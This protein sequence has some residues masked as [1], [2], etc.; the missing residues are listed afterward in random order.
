MTHEK[1]DIRSADEEVGSTSLPSTENHPV[2]WYRSTFY[3]ALILGLCNFLAPGIW[4]AMNSVG[5]GG[6]EKPYL[7]NA[8]NALTFCLMV[9]S[10]F[11]GSVVVRY[12]GIKWT[13][14]VGTMGYA[15]YAAGLYTNNRFG[16]EWFVLFGA[17]LCGLS[18]GIFWMAE[19]A[20]AISYPEPHN[21][22]RFLGFWLS[23]RVGGQILGGAINLGINSNRN[24]AG[25]VSYAVL[26]VF[27]VLQA[28]GP[29]AGLLLN[30]PSQVQRTDG[31]PVKL[32]IAHS[33]LHEI[34]ETAK[35][36]FTRNFLLIV[37]LISQAVFTEAVMFT[38]LSLWFSVRARALGSF[39][40]GIIALILGNLLG[41]FLDTKRISLKTRTRSAFATILTLQ[42][43]WWV[44]GTII[45]TEFKKTQPS[46]DWA[47]AG[48]GRGFALYL[49]W[50][51]GFQLN[52]M[53]LYF[54]IGNLADDEEE[55]IRISGLLRGTE[56]AAQAVSYGL[57]A[58]TI[59]A[60]V[61]SV[62]LNFGLWAIS[63]LPAWL[64][65][66]NIGVTLGDKKIQREIRVD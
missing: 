23:F 37:P 50:V 12:I 60:S 9:L 34:K 26:I 40:G 58:V 21:Q 24:T 62:Y 41:A 4:G 19:A 48:F 39:L 31:V 49:F 2:K 35:L 32:R 63:L 55:V 45:V 46:Y 5:G 20:I 25:S 16:T 53:F 33:P 1:E 66:K 54:L 22:G 42:G 8:A 38:Y 36:F 6:L 29:F 27:I 51:A 7:V 57:N 56:S 17:A 52:Y 10:C 30:T 43:A 61:G 44:W 47:D 13:L 18:A 15:P 3:N 11:F 64:V 14:I 59:M 65:V 28:L